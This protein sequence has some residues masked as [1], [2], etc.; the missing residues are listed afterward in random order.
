MNADVFRLGFNPL[1]NGHDFDELD[2]E[3]IWTQ[4]GHKVVQARMRALANKRP[5]LVPNEA[6]ME[7]FTSRPNVAPGAIGPDNR[8][9]SSDG[10]DGGG[11]H[12]LW[13][14]FYFQ[15][16]NAK[17]QIEPTVSIEGLERGGQL[18]NDQAHAIDDICVVLAHGLVDRRLERSRERVW[19][20]DFVEST[21]HGHLRC[22]G[23]R[24][25]LPPGSALESTGKAL[26]EGTHFVT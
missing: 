4:L 19:M 11:I 18:R 9:H 10:V 26:G 6:L 16:K 2:G 20:V 8:I 1:R 7:R 13:F 21:H 5:P 22:I 3:V 23:L 17:S 25:C 12:Y 14:T 15:K 24:K